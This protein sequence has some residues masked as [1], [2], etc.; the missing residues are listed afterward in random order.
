[1]LL[2]RRILE[3]GLLLITAASCPF[4]LAADG[5]F[6]PP[7]IQVP[8]GY[9]VELAAAPPL[10]KHPMLANFDDRGRLFIAE[11]AGKNLRRADL[12]KELPNFIRMI[13][14]T[15]GDGV[16][17]KSTIFADKL[18]YPQGALWHDGWLYVASS[19]AI[20]RFQDTDDDGVADIREQIVN[21]FGYTG[22]AADVHGCF[23]GPCG[24]IYWCEGRH[25]HEFRDD[26]GHVLSKGKAARIFSCRPDGSDVRVHCGG[27]MDNPV[28]IDFTEE[29]E[30]LGTVNIL[31]R[32]RGDC[33]VHWMHGGVYPRHDQPQVVAE[34]KRTGD[35][36]P[37]VIN[38]GHVAVS[39][40]TRYRSKHLGEDFQDNFFVTEFN[41]HKVVR[42]KLTRSGSTFSAVAEDF[43]AS[44]SND[45][46]PTDV[47]EDADGS[48]LVIDTGGWFRIGCPT[49][50]IAKPNILGAIYRVRR[51]DGPQLAFP[52]GPEGDWTDTS[53]LALISFL[54]D[55]RFAVRDRAIRVLAARGTDAV[56]K[57]GAAASSDSVV[58]RRNAVWAL[59][60]IAT[61]SALAILRTRLEDEDQSV[62]QAAAFAAGATADREAVSQ[63]KVLVFSDL[64]PAVRREAATALGKIGDPTAIQ[65]ILPFK[66]PDRV[67]EH[68]LIFALID[69]NDRAATIPW[70]AKGTPAEQRAALIALDQMDDGNLTRSDVTALLGTNDLALQRAAI[71]VVAR[72]PEW[73]EEVVDVVKSLLFDPQA[74]DDQLRNVRNLLVAFA[75]NEEVQQFITLKSAN[76]DTS[77]ERLV[78]L[79]DV[80]REC[81]LGELPKPWLAAIAGSLLSDKPEVVERAIAIVE[82]HNLA[83]LDEQL[84]KFAADEKH[85]VDLRVRA[86]AAGNGERAL[87]NATLQFL[88]SQLDDE[89]SVTQRLAAARAIGSS[90]LTSEQLRNVT[91]LV[92]SAG[93]L[94]LSSLL[95]A[96]EAESNDDVGRA[97]IAALH[98]SPGL[99]NLSPSLLGRVLGG[100]S[101][102]VQSD[103]EQLLVKLAPSSAEQMQRLAEL[104]T[105]MEGG[106]PRRGH[107]VFQAQRTSCVAC[108][109]VEGKGGRIGPDLSKLGARRNT[110]DLLEALVYPSASL[111]RG[112]ESFAVVSTDGKI[113]TGLI[114][115]E[116]ANA[117]QLRTT[118]QKEIVV[119]REDIEELQPST[120]S[121]M[122][123][124]LDR[125]M[126]TEDIRD[127]IAYLRSLK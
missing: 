42:T 84:R 101:A 53:N 18:T 12:E 88:T 50:Q 32:Q 106:D 107:A 102:E 124:G 13:E 75:E 122:P 117:I 36:L 126:S 76:P 27:G 49:S 35:L 45:F 6:A 82:R 34:F 116:T 96:Y 43:L 109:Q 89:V 105:S 47:L 28:E 46:H 95:G 91:K 33:L 120:V 68:A 62:R 83:T 40:T 61:P 121:I 37:P 29:G 57:L 38:L 77:L 112:F 19:G 73:S 52:R 56:G 54:D 60:R 39:G 15:N 100:F 81:S 65:A 127:L 44:T 72:H 48:L 14:D 10:V 103:S 94:E 30:M 24:R 80:I 58:M 9:E 1:M 118:D 115:S 70:L 90:K 113:H 93:P 97:V 123:A 79:L 86:L 20:W 23:L 64:Q 71:E 78:V 104:E 22:N 4:T 98:E 114:V 125:T 59:S 55:P 119:R 108:H 11:S 67:L 110:R 17:D 25:G 92:K 99:A 63:L 21:E 3:I 16:F 41:S 74:T 26:G 2:N 111:A 87:D 31:Y 85:A 69:I 8:D 5:D 66:Q 51:K 7:P